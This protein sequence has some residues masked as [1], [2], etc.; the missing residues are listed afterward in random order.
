MEE[1]EEEASLRTFRFLSLVLFLLLAPRAQ[2]CFFVFVSVSM[3]ASIEVSDGDAQCHESKHKATVH[4]LMLTRLHCPTILLIFS[5]R[6]CR[7][8]LLRGLVGAC[9][10]RPTRPRRCV[11]C[12]MTEWAAGVT[13]PSRTRADSLALFH[14]PF[15]LFCFVSPTVYATFVLRAGWRVQTDDPIAADMSL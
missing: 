13:K 11:R 3:P 10:Q 12:R 14:H 7:F 2:W 9:R 6:V 1:G 5:H 4:D 8:L 15:V